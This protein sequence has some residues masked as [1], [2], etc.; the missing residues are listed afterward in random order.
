MY[1]EGR[2][3]VPLPNALKTNKQGLTVVSVQPEFL[4]LLETRDRFGKKQQDIPY[5]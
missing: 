4:S 1:P 3:T 2:E 5:Y